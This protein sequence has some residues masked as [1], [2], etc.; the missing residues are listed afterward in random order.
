M[1]PSY[2]SSQILPK[3]HKE[4]VTKKILDYADYLHKKYNVGKQ[5][6]INLVDFMNAE[7]KS[8]ELPKMRNMTRKLDDIRNQNTKETFPFIAD[9]FD[10]N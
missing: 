2:Y 10:D 8:N 6:L 1:F 7:D 9:L 3:E 5:P 4:K